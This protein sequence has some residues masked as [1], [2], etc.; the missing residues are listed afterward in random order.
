MLA[1][2]SPP[3]LELQQQQQ[4]KGDPALTHKHNFMHLAG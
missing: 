1:L 4:L 2:A 3:Q